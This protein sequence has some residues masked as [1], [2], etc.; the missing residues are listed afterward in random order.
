[1]Y[2]KNKEFGTNL[3][4][5]DNYPP[6]ETIQKFE[7]PKQYSNFEDMNFLRMFC[8]TSTSPKNDSLWE[9]R[10]SY[11]D[12]DFGIGEYLI[13]DMLSISPPQ[14]SSRVDALVETLPPFLG[15]EP[16]NVIVRR[17]ITQLVLTD[18]YCPPPTHIQYRTV[19]TR[20]ASI[21]KV[22]KTSEIFFIYVGRKLEKVLV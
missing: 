21:R 17:L 2:K 1:M 19:L 6:F 10:R 22:Q 13:L 12:F 9:K 14:R 3:K 5:F 15:L 18:C 8:R 16:E 4:I 7:T 11:R 20:M